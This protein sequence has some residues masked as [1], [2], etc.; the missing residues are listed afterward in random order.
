MAMSFSVDPVS[1]K[2]A[3]TSYLL[4]IAFFLPISGWVADKWGTQKTFICALSLF[5]LSSIGCGLSRNLT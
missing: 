1:L 5:T 4:G 3:L 2:M